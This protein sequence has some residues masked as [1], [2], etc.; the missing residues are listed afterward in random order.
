MALRKRSRSILGTAISP[1][2][3][4]NGTSE[5]T[6]CAA[7]LRPR[8]P[9]GALYLFDGN[10]DGYSEEPRGREVTVK[11]K[12]MPNALRAHHG[13]A[14]RVDEAEVLVGVLSQQAVR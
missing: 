11:S 4:S 13:E 5:D 3:A 1:R 10:I 7:L 14:R 12:G 6:R 2:R 9:L 8:E